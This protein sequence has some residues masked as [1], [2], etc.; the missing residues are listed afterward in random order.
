MA[1]IGALFLYYQRSIIMG[2]IKAKQLESQLRSFIDEL[3]EEIRQHSA[4]KEY[5][6]AVHK[7][8]TALEE[9]G[10]IMIKRPRYQFET[11]QEYSIALAGLMTVDLESVMT[12]AYKFEKARYGSS[13]VTYDDFIEAETAF[14]VIIQ[15]LLSIGA[16]KTTELTEEESSPYPPASPSTESNDPENK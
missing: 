4:K 6:E 1:V 9:V 11:A 5:R 7:I 14:N 10:R 8:Y 16:I 15:T 13:E 12:I 3:L 2:S